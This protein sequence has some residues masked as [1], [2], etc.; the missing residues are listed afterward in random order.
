[1]QSFRN[2]DIESLSIF[3]VWLSLRERPGIFASKILY[4]KATSITFITIAA[5]LPSLM[6]MSKYQM[7]D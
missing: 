2:G 7:L 3:S 1:M 5:K 6:K 4:N